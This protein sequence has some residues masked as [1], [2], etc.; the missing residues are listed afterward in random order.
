MYFFY[1]VVVERAF[2]N[3]LLTCLHVFPACLAL[4]SSLPP[5]QPP[6]PC[7]LRFQPAFDP[8]PTDSRP[9]T[10][11][12]FHG[13]EQPEPEGLKFWAGTRRCGSWSNG[14]G[15]FINHV[16]TKIYRWQRSSSDLSYG[17]LILHVVDTRCE[18]WWW[19]HTQV[20]ART[21]FLHRIS[22][23]IHAHIMDFVK[24]CAGFC[25]RSER[26]EVFVLT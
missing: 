6:P 4:P 1:I 19:N 5:P 3:T 26:K 12:R 9:L 2:K 10:V 14:D 25:L 16:H 20:R 8:V 13:P 24:S 21:L 23:C 11:L 18:S 17:S 15:V 22:T 7:L